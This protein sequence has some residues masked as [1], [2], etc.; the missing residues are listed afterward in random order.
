MKHITPASE[1][2]YISVV[3]EVLNGCKNQNLLIAFFVNVNIQ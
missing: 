1:P 2:S 3:H